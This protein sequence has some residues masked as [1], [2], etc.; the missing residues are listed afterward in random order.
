MRYFKKIYIF[1]KILHRETVSTINVWILCNVII[2][3][4]CIETENDHRK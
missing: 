4:Y 3:Y 1:V 2:I